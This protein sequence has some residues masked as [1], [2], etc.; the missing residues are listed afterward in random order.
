MMIVQGRT[1][2]EVEMTLASDALGSPDIAPFLWAKGSRDCLGTV[3]K[4]LIRL[5]RVAKVKVVFR[6]QLSYIRLR[7]L[8]RTCWDLIRMSKNLPIY[9]R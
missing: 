5:C 4:E 6:R 3:V 2:G 9:A 1:R 7:N 8:D